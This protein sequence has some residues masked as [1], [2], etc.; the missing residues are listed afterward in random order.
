MVWIME[1]AQNYN[2]QL[3]EKKWQQYWSDK[4]VF[5][6]H[7][8][9]TREM[10]SIDTPP[11]TVSGK[12]HMGHAFSYTQQDVVARYMRM[13]GKNVFFPFGT[14]DNGLPT[15]RLIEKSRNINA[16]QVDRAAFVQICNEVVAVEKPKFIQ[17]WKDIGMSCDFSRSY[18]TISRHCQISSQA[19][20]IDLFHKGKIY[21]QESPVAWC[22]SCQ[23][24]I[25]QAEFESVELP[26][27]FNEIAFSVA[28]T[29]EKLVIATTRPEMIP[30]CVALCCHPDDAR[31]VALHGKMAI[32]PHFDYSVPIICDESVDIT[33]GTGLMMVC[34]FGDKEDVEKWHKHK[35]PLRVVF[36]KYGK[37]NA[38][39]GAFVGLKIK[40]ARV[41][42]IESLREKG[43]LISQ[44][45]IVHAVNVHER[46]KTEIEFLK[47]KQWYIRVLDARSDLL[48]VGSE[49][50]WYPAHMKVRY[51]HWV[52]NLGWDWCISRQRPFGIPIPVWFC[53]LCSAITVPDVADLPVDPS[54]TMPSRPCGCGS[55]SFVGEKDVLDTWATSSI[56]P[57]ISSNWAH[58]G[59]YDVVHRDAPFDLRPQ[60]HDIIRTW[61][62]YTVVKSYF[63]FGRAP[64]K[65][66]MISGHAQDPSG[67]KMSKSLG[68]IIE[69]QEM[70]VKYSADALRFW[71]A[72]ATLGDD[73]PFQDKDL[74]TG[75][76]FVTKLWNVMKFSTLHLQD[77]K[78]TVASE[79]LKKGVVSGMVQVDGLELFDR[80]LLSKLHKMITLSTARFD[81]LEYAK[82]KVEVEMFFW[83]ALCDNYLEIVK[84]RL[85]NPQVRGVSGR[86][87]AQFSLDTALLGVLKTMAPVMPHITEEIY[88]MRY[89][90]S[91]EMVSLHVSSWPIVP[92]QFLDAEVEKVG[93]M[94]V[95]VITT[96]RKYK[97]ENKWSMKEPLAVLRIAVGGLE[98]VDSGLFEKARGDLI[99]VTG[100]REVEFVSAVAN[101]THTTEQFKTT[102]EIVK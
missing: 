93:D 71:A 3:S 91:E 39:A 51:D 40:D 43:F 94:C 4:E 34:T 102:V 55:I 25:A 14:D 80:W 60:A 96:V 35:L 9:L 92:D 5:A 66:V 57:E 73:M 97:S 13:K 75:Q 89:A 7:A 27:H 63:H 81:A 68:N 83:H 52:E 79:T 62:F 10:F 74:M 45:S 31:Y 17:S 44:K 32:V 30:A 28:A 61:L 21:S 29:G 82:A 100:A 64:W 76:K 47:T 98:G 1:P 20:F 50:E 72:G 84:D 37:M 46:C 11:P 38:L 22:V 90:T 56:T 26:S 65:R 12:M 19:S 86:V 95:D 16:N 49:I 58:K 67:R 8:D 24:A 33:K 77:Y 2:A 69:P 54:L 88:Q 53:S 85:Y 36:E 101:V 48:R 23:T 87:S 99:A 15:E 6:F 78:S 59:E 18:S 41:K 42:I 70:I